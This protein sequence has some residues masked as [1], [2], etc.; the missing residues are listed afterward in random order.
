MIISEKQLLFLYQVLKDSIGIHG[1]CFGYD[2]DTRLKI[3]NE[4]FNQ[5]SEKLREVKE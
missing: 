2:S 1:S 4:I 3:L 5:Q